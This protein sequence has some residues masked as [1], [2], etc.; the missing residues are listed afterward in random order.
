MLNFQVMVC[1][2]KLGQISPILHHNNR[3]AYLFHLTTLTYCLAPGDFIDLILT[4]FNLQHKQH[5][6]YETKF[7]CKNKILF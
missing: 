3:T 6:K 7:N 5:G 4:Y 2:C 1:N